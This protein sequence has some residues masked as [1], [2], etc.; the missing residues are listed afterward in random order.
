MLT[1]TMF[2]NIRYFISQGIKGV[3]ANRLMS[4]ASIGIVTAS[5]FLFGFFILLG[6]NLNYVSDQIRQQCEINVYL[7][8]GTPRDAVREVGSKLSLIPNVKEARLYTKE[9]RFQDY[10]ESIYSDRAGVIDTLKEDNPL[11]DAYILELADIEVAE[12][13]AEAAR[14]VSGVEEVKDSRHIF[15]KIISITNAVRHASIWFVFILT[16][17]SIFIISNTIKLG[18]FSRRR[19]INIMKFVGATN[20]FI[21]FPFMIEG[22]ILGFIGAALSSVIIIIS[23]SAILPQIAE[24]MGTI[25]LLDTQSVKSLVM[26]S[27]GTLGI[28]IGILGSYMSIRKHLHV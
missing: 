16:I 3:L 27:F 17:I 12:E 24:F 6:S 5:L 20:W 25:K 9:E 18:M 22:M 19:E 28:G 26:W 13:V 4:L 23:Y 1:D 10:K 14:K 11:R 2:R 15:N 7:P 21:R 8:K